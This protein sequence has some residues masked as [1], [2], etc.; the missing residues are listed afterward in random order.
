MPSQ[1]RDH[2]RE[3]LLQLCTA[4]TLGA[5]IATKLPPKRQREDHLGRAQTRQRDHPR[6]HPRSRSH[7]EARR[8]PRVPPLEDR[9]G[10]REERY[11]LW[12]GEEDGDDGDLLA[13][14]EQRPLGREGS[15]R[16]DED[17][18]EREKERMAYQ[19]ERY[20]RQNGDE[21]DPDEQGRIVRG[22]WPA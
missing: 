17:M 9:Q 7:D 3:T 16:R 11:Y 10:Y 13:V 20:Y 1:H 8:W 14:V 2:H 18:R 19:V 5:L 12:Y 6:D 22:G 4:I 15:V 21:A